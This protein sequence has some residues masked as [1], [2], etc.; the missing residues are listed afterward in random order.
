MVSS[1]IF[2]VLTEYI[3]VT[4]ETKGCSTLKSKTEKAPMQ[5][6]YSNKFSPEIEIF[7][8]YSRIY[9]FISFYNYFVIDNCRG[10]CS[11]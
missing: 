3:P 6:N 7:Y 8:Y 9:D 5:E 10:L 1:I 11:G 4:N 2:P